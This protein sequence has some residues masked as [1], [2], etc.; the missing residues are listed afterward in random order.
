MALDFEIERGI[1]HG[2]WC[3]QG[4]LAEDGRVP[5]EYNLKE[6]PSQDYRFRTW[7][8]VLDSD[9][10]LVF[11]GV[12]KLAGGTKHTYDAAAVASKPVLH[13]HVGMGTDNAVEQL[14]EF[15]GL[16]PV[17]T[18]NVAGPRASKLWGDLLRQFVFEVLGRGLFQ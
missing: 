14:R 17:E 3:P 10:T 12:A 5:D 15:L 7:L 4:R 9:A 16:L 11:T 13:L 1:P 6:C 2:G 18:L 8:N